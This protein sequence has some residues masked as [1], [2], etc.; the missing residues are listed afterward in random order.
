MLILLSHC[1]S[2][3]KAWGPSPQPSTPPT[4]QADGMSFVAIQELQ[5]EQETPQVKDKRSLKEIQEEEQAQQQEEEF[6]RWWA[7]EEERV[8]QENEATAALI[9]QG[10]VGDDSGQ[11]SSSRRKGHPRGQKKGGVRKSTKSAGGTGK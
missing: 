11:S 4:T 2:T 1:S 6:L 8:R 5:R 10:G 9:A 3:G 7:A